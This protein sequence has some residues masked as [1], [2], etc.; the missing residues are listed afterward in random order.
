MSTKTQLSTEKKIGRPVKYTKTLIDQ[1][2]TLISQGMNPTEAVKQCKLTWSNFYNHVFNDDK[3]KLA[4]E[5]AKHAGADFKV[6][7]YHQLLE[8]L[9]NSVKEDKKLNMSTIKGLEILQK[10]LHWYAGKA[11]ATHYGSDK[12]RITLTSGDQSFSIEWSK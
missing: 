10:Q 4:Y 12:E 3:M 9:Q 6:S 11:A 8:D 7:E 1:V 5:Q 2:F